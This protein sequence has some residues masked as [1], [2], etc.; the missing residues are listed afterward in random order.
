M[1]NF[2]KKEKIF[3]IEKRILLNNFDIY[4]YFFPTYN[5]IKSS[6]SLC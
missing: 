5:N 2:N 3:F 4:I 6:F 1:K